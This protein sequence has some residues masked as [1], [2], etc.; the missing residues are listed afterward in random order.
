M[1]LY[2]TL[3]GT[4]LEGF[5][6]DVTWGPDRALRKK[7]GFRFKAGVDGITNITLN[8]GAAGKSKI[9]VKGTNVALPTLPLSQDPEVVVQIS[10]DGGE[11]WESRF[12]TAK[13]NDAKKF[14]AK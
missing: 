11:C 13:K 4:P 14:T 8:A 12:A 3:G 9:Q 10:N 6:A 2:D 7:K 5:C 1:C